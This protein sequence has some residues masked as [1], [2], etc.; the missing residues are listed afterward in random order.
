MSYSHSPAPEMPVLQGVDNT[1][2]PSP[3]PG[4][5]Q[6]PYRPLATPQ[7]PY[8]VPPGVPFT[9]ANS[10]SYNMVGEASQGLS[11]AL[12]STPDAAQVRYSSR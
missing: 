3:A 6:Q 1:F 2:F 7:S 12:A 4:S 8:L 11:P 5:I 10:A 9:S